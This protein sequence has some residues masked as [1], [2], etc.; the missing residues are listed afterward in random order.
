MPSRACR[1]IS[2]AA[3]SLAQ[4]FLQSATPAKRNFPEGNP[5]LIKSR[6]LVPRTKSN[7]KPIT[8]FS[9]VNVLQASAGTSTKNVSMITFFQTRYCWLQL[10]VGMSKCM[11]VVRIKIHHKA[12]LI[13]LKTSCSSFLQQFSHNF[14]GWKMYQKKS[15][16][17]ET[18]SN[19]QAQ[20]NMPW[21]ISPS[22]YL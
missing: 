10:W 17:E 3:R 19:I 9:P 11:Q 18:K 12:T 6:I 1:V 13:K 20:R 7:P 22:P 14:P 15:L 4:M 2:E 5:P 21:G 16:E 8:P